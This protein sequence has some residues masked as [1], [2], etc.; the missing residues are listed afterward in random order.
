MSKETKLTGII[1]KKQP[2]NEG[3]EIITLFT[4]EQGKLRVLAK[5]VKLAKSKLQN[6]LQAL[7]LVNISV[8]GNKLPKIIA[9]QPEEVFL[10]LRENLR[11]VKMAFY[12][13]ELLLKFTPDEH[14][15]EALF[16]LLEQ[17]LSKLNTEK[18]DDVLNLALAKFK[19]AILQDSGLGIHY[20]KNISPREKVS[21]SPVRGGFVSGE[22]GASFLPVSKACFQLFLKLAGVNSTDIS[23]DS[24]AIQE[25]QKL[26]SIFIEYQLER[27]VNSEKY[28][29]MV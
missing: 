21:L 23:Q 16:N 6:S 5:S 27:R 3:D 12:A 29:N 18:S 17:F 8:A 28:L 22:E 15:N 9:A 24:S 10:N 14:K 11:A 26:L 19:I 7:F 2:Y 4:K 20:P 1:L 25:L 13:V